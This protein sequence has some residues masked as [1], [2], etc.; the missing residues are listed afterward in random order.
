MWNIL[1]NWCCHLF[2]KRLVGNWTSGIW[3][4]SSNHLSWFEKEILYCSIDCRIIKIWSEFYTSNIIKL[5][6]VVFVLF[7]NSI[8]VG[9]SLR[10]ALHR[11]LSTQRNKNKKRSSMSSSWINKKPVIRI[12]WNLK[13][14]NLHTCI[15]IFSVFVQKQK[16]MHYVGSHD[17]I[18]TM[19]VLYFIIYDI[20]WND[21]KGYS[22]H[23]N[24][25]LNWCL[26]M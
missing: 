7:L 22:T 1:R 5:N 25:E 14:A 26:C 10:R 16:S 15:D 23:G 19:S 18:I 11:R 17:I 8:E 21:T 24:I 2:T 13:V 12:K 6:F 3:T 9:T 20:S 4:D